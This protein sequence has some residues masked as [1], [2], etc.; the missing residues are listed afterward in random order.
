MSVFDWRNKPRTTGNERSRH[1]V[2]EP[3]PLRFNGTIALSN[4]PPPLLHKFYTTTDTNKPAA[5]CD[6]NGEV[7]L[8]QCKVCR[9]AENELTDKPTC[10][11]QNDKS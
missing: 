6:R 3:E 10:T 9:L 2:V 8:Q 11:K 1:I 4:N 5:I 7:V